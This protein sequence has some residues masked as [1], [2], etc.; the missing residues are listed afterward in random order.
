MKIPPSQCKIQSNSLTIKLYQDNSLLASM[1]I[2]GALAKLLKFCMKMKMY[3]FSLREGV[4]LISFHGHLL[5]TSD[6]NS[7]DF[8]NGDTLTDIHDMFTM[9][10][11]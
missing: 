5:L 11:N 2:T 8:Q 10:I 4:Q 7:E 6:S 1:M 9:L 3:I